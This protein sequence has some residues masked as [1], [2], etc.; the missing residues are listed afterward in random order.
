MKKIASVI[1]FFCAV[2]V[3]SFAQNSSVVNAYIEQYK[4]IA[5][6]E[7]LRTGVPAAITLAQ[8]IVESYAGQSDFV[9]ASNNHFG[10]KCKN[11]WS[12]DVVYHDD[13]VKNECFRSYHSAEESYKD[14]SDFLSSR[15]KYASLFYLDPADYE[16]WAK[17]LK[18]A[19]YA[20]NP[21][22][23][24]SLIKTITDYNLQ[25]YTLFALQ[26]EEKNNMPMLAKNKNIPGSL[27]QSGNDIINEAVVHVDD[28]AT[29]QKKEINH[30]P[31]TEFTINETRVV[32]LHEGASLFA[33]ASKYHISYKKL[34][35]F[36]ELDNT[37]LLTKNKLIF[38]EKKP[39]RGARDF[40][41]VND[42]ET[43]EAISQQEGVQL[44]SL[45]AYNNISKGTQLAAG[46]KIY[47]R[48]LDSNK[49][50]IFKR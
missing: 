36:N 37:D 4:D 8:G 34:L 26:Q 42:D 2:F 15:P 12:G 10:I 35:K 49:Q 6:S 22:Y 11:E 28:G 47:L 7:E 45:L 18:K 50:S 16:H 44:E 39:K 14:H 21:V 17:G 30:Y 32:Y 3:S 40:H 33:T 23:A 38:L 31:E 27:K 1:F 24:Q 13:D 48:P 5:I 43:I 20:T 19:G 46:N 41:I 25:E 9:K 29:V